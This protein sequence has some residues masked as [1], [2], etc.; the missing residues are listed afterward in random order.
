MA[1]LDIAAYTVLE[2]LVLD[3]LSGSFPAAAHVS[4]QLYVGV[5]RTKL[6]EGCAMTP[7]RGVDLSEHL[8]YSTLKGAANRSLGDQIRRSLYLLIPGAGDEITLEA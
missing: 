3:S 4:G 2:D 5:P 8:A 1:P 6:L 7:T